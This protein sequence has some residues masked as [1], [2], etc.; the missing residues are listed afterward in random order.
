MQERKQKRNALQS[1]IETHTTDT[2]RSDLS[3]TQQLFMSCGGSRDMQ[4]Y[5]FSRSTSRDVVCTAS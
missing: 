3:R 2:T 1:L 4:K 5:T